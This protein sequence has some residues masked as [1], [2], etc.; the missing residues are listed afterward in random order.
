MNAMSNTFVYKEQLINAISDTCSFLRSE[1]FPF[2][3]FFF[4]FPNRKKYSER[5]NPHPAGTD[6][7][8]AGGE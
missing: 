3:I 7:R 2:F 5:F 8:A 1:I 4:K 6:T